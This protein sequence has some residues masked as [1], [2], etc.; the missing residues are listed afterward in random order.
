MPPQ[1]K[2]LP[3]KALRPQKLDQ[4]L[5]FGGRRFY[6][7]S[8]YFYFSIFLFYF[9]LSPYFFSAA[10]SIALTNSSA[11]ILPAASLI[12]FSFKSGSIS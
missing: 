4:N 2:K 11:L 6:Q 10:F 5:T 1:I 8:F 12:K 7:Q 9:S 3:E